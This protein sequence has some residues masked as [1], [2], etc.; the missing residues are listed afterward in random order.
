MSCSKAVMRI[1]GVSV[2]AVLVGGACSCKSG[3]QT[4]APASQPQT[5]PAENHADKP[6]K[7]N[8][9]A[10]VVRI[11]GVPIYEK[12]LL[13]GMPA[14]ADANTLEETRT[15][16]LKEFAHMIFVEQLLRNHKIEV[17]EQ[18]I[19]ENMGWF[20]KRVT[21]PD[22]DD[23]VTNLEQFRKEMGFTPAD[24]RRAVRVDV[25]LR[26]YAE[27]LT[28]ERLDP[29]ALAKAASESRPKI[30]QEYLKASG[31]VFSFSQKANNPDELKA[32]MDAKK[33]QANHAWQRLQAKEPFDVVAKEMS[34]DP[35]TA[36]KGGQ[37]GI[38]PFTCM[39]NEVEAVLRKLEVGKYSEPIFTSW[40]YAIVLR[41]KMSDEDIV[42][43]LKNLTPYQVND[44]I[45]AELYA[46]RSKAKYEYA[47]EPGAT[48]SPAAP[49]SKPAV[50]AATHPNV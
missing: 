46:L 33:K 6:I 13:N 27:E 32:V 14:N 44:A 36:G 28:K 30:E 37:L 15:T 10:L 17:T 34:D 41:E 16:K 40:Y 49:A 7:R 19:D 5:R 20:E 25:G 29:N 45:N 38:V 42:N 18:Q 4:P 11:N 24:L 1:L 23:G 31:I 50:T 35:E 8:P 47:D 21:G 12:D 43:L 22:S 2:V 9:E 3:G 26:M 48:T 39:G